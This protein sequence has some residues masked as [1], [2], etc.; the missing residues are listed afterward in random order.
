MHKPI[1][2]GC[3]HLLPSK[4]AITRNKHLNEPEENEEVVSRPVPFVLKL[5]PIIEKA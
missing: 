1:V 5:F 4:I 3:I 2:K